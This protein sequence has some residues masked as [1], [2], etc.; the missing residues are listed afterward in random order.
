[1]IGRK[2]QREPKSVFLPIIFLPVYFLT[3]FTIGHSY[4]MV[5]MTMPFMMTRL[6]MRN[7]S[8]GGMLTKTVAAMM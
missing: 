8:S 7:T 6:A 1:M 3:Y 4:A 2:I 5:G